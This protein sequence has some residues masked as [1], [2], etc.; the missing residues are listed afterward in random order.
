M[1]LLRTLIGS[2]AIASSLTDESM[3][4]HLIRASQRRWQR[5]AEDFARLIRNGHPLPK[6]TTIRSAVYGNMSFGPEEMRFIESYYL[7]RLR[8]VSQMGL[9]HLVYPDARHSRFEHSLGV[10]WSLKSLLTQDAHVAKTLKDDEK[11]TLFF[12]ALLHDCGHGP[13]SHTTETLLEI[14]GLDKQLRRPVEGEGR[15]VK[16]HERR[17]RDMVQDD[18]FHLANL[19][20][21]SYGLREALDRFGVDPDDVV[22]LILGLSPAPLL[23]LLSGDFDVDKMDYF[24]RDA[25]FTGTMGGGVDMEALQ[26][27]VRITR[28]DGGFP[29][30]SYDSRVVGHLL[31][32]LYSREHVYGVTAYHPVARIAAAMLLVAGD[33]ALRALNPDAG[34]LLFCNLELLDDREF[35]HGLELGA[36][37]SDHEDGVLLR[38]VIQRLY[39]RRLPKRL[40]TLTRGE[41]TQRF[42]QC[43]GPLEE[44]SRP[45]TLPLLA[46]CRISDIANGKY[47]RLFGTGDEDDLAILDL[48]PQLGSAAKGPG[49]F[50]GERN[51]LDGISIMRG[52]HSTASLSEWLEESAGQGAADSAAQALRVYKLALWRALVL[53]PASLKTALVEK[54]QVDEFLDAFAAA[55]AESSVRRPFGKTRPWGPTHSLAGTMIKRWRTDLAEKRGDP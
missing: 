41:F 16:P 44:E 10:L 29:R 49:E 31:H 51:T 34:A 21:Q 25:F 37:D 36:N 22:R 32:L 24:R 50:E 26:R 53:V 48:S 8:H 17:A 2:T 38:K 15:K 47:V 18:D 42:A 3:I 20:I 30:A 46:Y 54:K 5:G 9:I 4:D 1:A 14:A 6:E 45:P 39:L 52:R 35:L 27:W 40:A 12:A 23:N 55:L 11:R 19:D 33:L 28:Q 43:I 13:F 7:Q